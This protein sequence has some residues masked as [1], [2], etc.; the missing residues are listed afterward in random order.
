MRLRDYFDRYIPLAKQAGVGFLLESLTWRASPGWTAQ[1][2][3]TDADMA[4]INRDSI[5][6]L[7]G[8]RVVHE[9]D[10]TPMVISGCAGPRGDYDPGTLMSET[11][12][13]AYHVQKIA[14]L[15]DTAADLISALTMNNVPEAV[16][17]TRAG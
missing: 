7:E 2:G 3:L 4:R 13:E 14:V 5:A 15:A 8:L 12:A 1:L 10:E 6:F 11:D 9:T 16:G 17:V